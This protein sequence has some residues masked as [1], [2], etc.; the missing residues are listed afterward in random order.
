MFYSGGTEVKLPLH[1]S[2]SDTTST[3]STESTTFVVPFRA[4]LGVFSMKVE[5]RNNM[6]ITIRVY[7]IPSC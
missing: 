7:K 3:T 5:S 2:V 6:E 1:G 4:K